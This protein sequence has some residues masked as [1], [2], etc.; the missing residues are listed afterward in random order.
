MS[1]R[2]FITLPEP[3]RARGSDPELSFRA[4]GAEAFAHELQAALRSPALFE[5]WRAKQDDPDDVDPKLGEVDP[6]AQV[7][8]SQNDLG[9]DLVAQTTLP[10]SLLQQRLRWLA[11][12]AWRLHDVREGED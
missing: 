8:G 11:G 12:S 7:S 5:R 3:A 2:F 1:K 9:I 4:H 10:G 6:T